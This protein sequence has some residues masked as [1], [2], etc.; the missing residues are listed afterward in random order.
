LNRS[1]HVIKYGDNTNSIAYAIALTGGLMF[2]LYIV[3][4]IFFNIYVPWLMHAETVRLLFKIDPRKPKKPRSERRMVKKEPADL[5]REARENVKNQVWITSSALD[6]IVLTIDSFMSFCFSSKA[7]KFARIVQDG[8][9]QVK[10]EMNIL[11]F[12]R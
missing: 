1:L 2:C 4:K 6:R 9:H 5:I 7:N 12:M 11:K 10:N 3:L 8:T